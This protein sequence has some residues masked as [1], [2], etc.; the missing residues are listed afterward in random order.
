MYLSCRLNEVLK[1]GSERVT[2]VG[3]QC[4]VG[5]WN[6]K[7]YEPREEVSQVIELAVLLV[8][9]ID[10]TPPILSPSDR[11]TIDDDIAF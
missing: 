7:R 11:F 5:R 3:D 2:I 9:D 4:Y 8:L 10:D 1:M 6:R